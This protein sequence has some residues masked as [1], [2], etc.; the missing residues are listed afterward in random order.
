MMVNKMLDYHHTVWDVFKNWIFF[1]YM[2]DIL[3]EM[4]FCTCTFY[5]SNGSTN[6]GSWTRAN[7]SCFHVSDDNDFKNGSRTIICT[8]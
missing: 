2:F 4:Y 3:F 8:L 7:A 6:C 1:D 5:H